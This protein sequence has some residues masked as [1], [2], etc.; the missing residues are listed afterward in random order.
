MH[1]QH[2]HQEKTLLKIREIEKQALLLA[3]TNLLESLLGR[4]PSPEEITNALKDGW[5]KW[6]NTEENELT[7]LLAQV[8]H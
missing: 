7:A 6:K 3:V 4:S 1:I 8:K 5:I 2:N